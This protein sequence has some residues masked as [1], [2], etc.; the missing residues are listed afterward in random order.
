MNRHFGKLGDVWKH[1]PLAE[2]LRLK[3]PLHYWETHAGSAFYHMDR[4]PERLHGAIRFASSAPNDP[5]LQSCAY[6][7]LLQQNLDIYPGS[8]MIAMQLL[9]KNA[10]YLF[11]DTDPESASSLRV[12]SANFNARIKE[13][14]GMLSINEEAEAARVCPADTF[15]HIDPFDPHERLTPESRTPIELAGVLAKAGYQVLYWYG[16]DSE[17][18]R[19]WAFYEFANIAPNVEFWC[20]DVLMPASFIYPDR[21]GAWGCGIVLANATV[22]EIKCCERLGH[23]LEKISESDVM[24]GNIPERLTFEIWK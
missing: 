8:G 13:R 15:V 5:D 1:L 3:P 4:S 17:A 12:A 19:G 10:D 22:S 16:Y 21:K 20:G 18:E 2:I 9:G 14:D 11:C 24:E 6:L 23:A 7:E